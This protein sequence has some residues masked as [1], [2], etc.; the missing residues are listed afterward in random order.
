LVVAFRL[1]LSETARAAL[2]EATAKAHQFGS[3]ELRIQRF[4]GV[5]ERESDWCVAQ[6]SRPRTERLAFQNADLRGTFIESQATGGD[7]GELGWSLE[8]TARALFL[9][10]A[11]LETVVHELRAWAAA[12]GV[13]IGERVRRVDPAADFERWP[14][15]EDDARAMVRHPRSTMVSFDHHETKTYRE[16][17][18]RVTGFVV[19]PGNPVMLR[20]YDKTAELEAKLCSREGP[21]KQALERCIW[22]ENGWQGGRVTRVEFQVRGEAC[23]ELFKRSL[24]GLLRELDGLWR[25]LVDEKADGKP[26]WARMV[27][28]DT[29]TRAR[30]AKLDPRWQAVRDVQFGVKRQPM[31]RVRFRG[32][33]TASQ[34]WSMMLAALAE[35]EAL[36]VVLDQA[37]ELQALAA[38]S[39][40]ESERIAREV[41]QAVA[42]SFVQVAVDS[43]FWRWGTDAV[44]AM[45]ARASAARARSVMVKQRREGQ[46]CNI[47]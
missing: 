9:A 24:D 21:T 36:P 43:Q 4:V 16:Q 10:R 14:I 17:S 25:Y 37:D 2:R 7:D 20:L 38:S 28:L 35:C 12:F 8:L 27:L 26:G 31:R 6:L 18:D 41:A 40:A 13:V 1:Q 3:A 23:Q 47:E 34:A 42:Q 33:A 22:R 19:C 29:A 15:K 44:P 46:A 5:G 30:R 32:M 45:L 39:P 11:G